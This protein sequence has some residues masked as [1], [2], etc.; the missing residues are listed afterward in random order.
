MKNYFLLT[1]M[2]IGLLLIG[3]G[4]KSGPDLSPEASRK[5]VKNL[6]DWMIE[7]PEK[8]GFKYTS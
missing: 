6:P 3:C 4:S 5:T 2:T 8:K 7:T 1:I